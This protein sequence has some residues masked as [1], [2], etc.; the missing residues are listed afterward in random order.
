LT[1]RSPESGERASRFLRGERRRGRGAHRSVVRGNYG[2]AG[3]HLRHQCRV[4]RQRRAEGA[5]IALSNVLFVSF[6]A[7]AP[8]APGAIIAVVAVIAIVQTIATAFSLGA[9]KPERPG[10]R[11]FWFA[12]LAVYALELY[13]AVRLW[14]WSGPAEGL[15][16]TVLALYAY[17]L[18]SAWAL[19]GARDN[20]KG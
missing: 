9:L 20:A 16:Y 15:V 3:A 10:I 13:I 12:P 7:L 6:A 8:H 5:F 14:I 19:L 4:L 17:S 18:G 2:S 11:S 1:T